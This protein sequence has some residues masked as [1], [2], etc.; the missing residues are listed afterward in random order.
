MLG[1]HK[2]PEEEWPAYLHRTTQFME[3]LSERDGY[4]DWYS[5]HGKR[6]FRLAGRIA[7]S[8]DGQW[9]QRLMTWIPWF[10][11]GANEGR[12]VGRLKRRWAKTLEL[13]AGT[14]WP[15]IAKDNTLWT[16][17]ETG[18]IMKL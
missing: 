10:Q 6:L 13:H 11:L 18:F 1:S 9:A 16:L 17:L 12:K 3:N 15:A 2:M 7:Q 4:Q 5:V 8:S 14:R